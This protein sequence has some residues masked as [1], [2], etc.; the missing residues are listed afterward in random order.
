MST[1]QK[2]QGFASLSIEKLREVSAQGGRREVRK[3]FATLSPEERKE[4]SKKAAEIRWARVKA[5]RREQNE[6]S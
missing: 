3:G 6:Q 4:V 2:K 1:N 5:N